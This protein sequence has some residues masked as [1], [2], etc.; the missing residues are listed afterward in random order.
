MTNEE[1]LILLEDLGA[2]LPYDIDINYKA[3]E[4][5]ILVAINNNGQ[6]S[7]KFYD[8]ILYNV[9][10]ENIKPYLYLESEL[11]D[12]MKDDAVDNNAAVYLDNTKKY[13][14]WKNNLDTYKWCNRNKVDYRH[15][16]SKGFAL[17][18]SSKKANT[19]Y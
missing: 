8:S 4:D 14:V 11:T 12:D 13:F 16:I 3:Q 2:R 19:K 9:D 18:M 10:I 6:C 15:L 17:P 1:K 7:I 5:G